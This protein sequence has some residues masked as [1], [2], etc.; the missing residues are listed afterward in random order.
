MD[1]NKSKPRL[2]SRK[3]RLVPTRLIAG[4]PGKNCKNSS[5]LSCSAIQTILES[6]SEGYPCQKIEESL[7][8]ACQP[9]LL[10]H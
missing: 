9:I 2:R 8:R 3:G 6:A 7:K 5:A 1:S 10:D 4:T